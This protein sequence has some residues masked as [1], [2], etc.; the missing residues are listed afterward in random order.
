[1]Q[2]FAVFM[3]AIH[4]QNPPAVKELLAYMFTIIKA[5]QD[6]KDPSWRNYDKVFR[7]KAT[8]T[9]IY[10]RIFNLLAMPRNSK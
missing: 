5:A 7:K 1:M 6:F 8:D 10:N 9:L 3:A 4:K 2:C